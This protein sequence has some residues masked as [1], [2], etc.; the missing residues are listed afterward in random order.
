MIATVIGFS[1]RIWLANG[2]PD[3]S[4][5]TSLGLYPDVGEVFMN[6]AD[7]AFFICT[8]GGAS[9]IWE[10]TTNSSVVT[11]LIESTV[12]QSDWNQTVISS[13]DYIK[14]K[15]ALATVATSGSYNDLSAKPSLST[16]AISG[17]Y[18][19]LS[20]KPSIPAAQIQS[21]WTQ[22]NISTLDYIK[23]KPVLSTVAISGSYNDLLSKP[24]IPATQVQSDWNETN[25][26]ALDYIKNKPAAR[27]QS[28]ASRSLNTAFQ[29]S[30]TRWSTV[31]YSVDISTTVS[32]SGSATGTVILETATNSGFTTGVQTLQQFSNGNSG[33]LVVGLVLTQL[34][35]ACLSGDV[36]PGN[37]VRLRT[38]N[39]TGTPTYTYQVGQ[40][41]LI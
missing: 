14:N 1:I 27:S 41:T 22:T 11:S 21:D 35:T 16:V 24:T 17:S 32:L 25:T 13:Q 23:N 19:D 5:Q 30:S 28:S 12:L 26:S 34:N 2:D 38:V 37:Y 6:T 20:S 10:P 31:R 9:Q 39:V 18:N 40:E 33:T 7:G 15:P 29:V 8:Q 3:S 4:V 36:P